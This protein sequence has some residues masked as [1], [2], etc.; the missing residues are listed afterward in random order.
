MGKE[1]KPWF[2]GAVSL[3]VLVGVAAA[4]IASPAVSLTSAEK[5]QVKKIVKKQVKKMA[6]NLKVG[7]AEDLANVRYIKGAET[8]VPADGT[9]HLLTAAICPSGT[10][11]VGGG[12]TGSTLFRV[13]QSY[14]TAANGTD[15]G[16]Q[17]WTVLVENTFSGG[18]AADGRAVAICVGADTTS[19]TWP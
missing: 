6:P 16:R 17:G 18:G 11:V 12:H 10:T 2:R 15:P 5:K 3:A 13:A 4:L 1:R 7:S 14:P 19:G 9:E 8:S